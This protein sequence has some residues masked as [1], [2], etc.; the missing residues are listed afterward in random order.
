VIPPPRKTMQFRRLMLMTG[1]QRGRSC[2]I[3]LIEVMNDD[4]EVEF[5]SVG[6]YKET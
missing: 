6:K 5:R 4:E 2:L 3:P 1:L